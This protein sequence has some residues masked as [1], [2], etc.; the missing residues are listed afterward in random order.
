[1][2][3]D[4]SDVRRRVSRMRGPD[5]S[6]DDLAPALDRAGRTLRD[7]RKSTEAAL[8]SLGDLS[9][10]SLPQVSLDSLPGRRRPSPIRR[11]GP[12]IAIGL[13]GVLAGLMIGWWMATMA[14]MG[15]PATGQ[16]AGWRTRGRWSRDLDAAKPDR[17][18]NDT[19]WSIGGQPA[20]TPSAS[21]ETD[22]M[23]SSAAADRYGESRDLESEST[24]TWRGVGP[25]RSTEPAG[26]PEFAS[27]TVR[28]D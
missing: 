6:T 12:V 25:G 28:G 17:A 26:T 20:S 13:I 16:A 4:F 10:D 23:G 27:R 8:A 24:D 21:K 9:L 3:I 14:R 11:N 18:S 5:V 2:A 19:G 7:W 22:A 15:P 1:M